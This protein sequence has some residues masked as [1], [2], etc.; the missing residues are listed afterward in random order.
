[1]TSIVISLLLP[2]VKYPAAK[3]SGVS[4]RSFLTLGLSMKIL[5]KSQSV[6]IR[7]PLLAAQCSMLLPRRP[8]NKNLPVTCKLIAIEIYSPFEC[9][10]R[11][12]FEPTWEFWACSGAFHRAHNFHIS[13]FCCPVH[14]TIAFLVPFE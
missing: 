5:S 9:R 4:P 8:L 14:G 7:R 13:S 12:S 10:I 6:N 1:M 3:C 2:L 11:S